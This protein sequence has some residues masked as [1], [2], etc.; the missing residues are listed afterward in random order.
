MGRLLLYWIRH[1][2]RCWPVWTTVGVLV[3]VDEWRAGA[4]PEAVLSRAVGGALL[5]WTAVPIGSARLWWAMRRFRRAAG[6]RVVLRFDPELAGPDVERRL[7]QWQR[8]LEEMERQFGFRLKRRLVVCEFARTAQLSRL[9]GGSVG[10]AALIRA[11]ALL[12]AAD[13]MELRP[14]ELARHESAHL[15][16]AYWG[17]VWPSLKGEGLATWLQ[18][19][20]FGQ[21]LDSYAL[22]WF[23]DGT[24]RPLSWM[25]P[26]RA[27]HGDAHRNYALAGSFTGFLIRRF[28]WE[29]YHGFFRRAR[30]RNFERVFQGVYGLSLLAAERQWRDEILQQ[31]DPLDTGE[32]P[33]M[34]ERRLEVAA[35]GWCPRRCITL[36][37][38]LRRCGQAI[39]RATWMAASYHLLLA[40]YEAARSMLSEAL[41]RDDPRL[42]ILRA[43][44]WMQ[45]GQACDLAGEREP[46]RAAYQQALKEPDW[47]DP[48]RGSAHAEARRR[49]KRPYTE[50]EMLLKA[51][52]RFLR[53][54]R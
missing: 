50:R 28:G 40:E 9:S 29:T 27:F 24:Y 26:E 3:A 4:P 52:R 43:L 21:P 12:V 47:W 33:A 17:G 19:T 44:M 51:R 49:L 32:D 13:A 25:L 34:L 23:L 41:E 22:A 38:H 16:S 54:S 14:Q 37:E 46:A 45:L 7:A 11:D 36:A 6:E 15:F 18:G 30:R 20:L 5:T 31:H 10:A 2:L 39:G 48:V 1:V 42:R 8:V 53:R 35:D